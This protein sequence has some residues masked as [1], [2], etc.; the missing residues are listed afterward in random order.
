M[1]V[2]ADIKPGRRSLHWTAIYH[3]TVVIPLLHPFPAPR[4]SCISS[5]C[6]RGS[7]FCCL[8]NLR[9][10]P[11][12][13]ICQANIW[14]C[15]YGNSVGYPGTHCARHQHNRVMMGVV[16]SRHRKMQAALCLDN[17]SLSSAGATV[18]HRSFISYVLYIGVF[19]LGE[20]YVTSPTLSLAEVRI[21]DNARC[22]RGNRTRT[23]PT[24]P[25]FPV[26]LL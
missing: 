4:R 26:L 8:A 25:Y 12:Q 24:A 3:Q 22:G 9:T 1:Q 16:T 18:L 15:T 21:S 13:E 14:T 17:R 20:A 2:K 23:S 7:A 6:T 10:V 5:N 19:I 11:S